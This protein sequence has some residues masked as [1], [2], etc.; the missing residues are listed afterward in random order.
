[1]SNE[2][3]TRL[4]PLLAE[5]LVVESGHY[6]LAS[7]CC[8]DEQVPMTIKSPSFRIQ[9]F[10]NFGLVRSWRDIKQGPSR[11]NRIGLIYRGR[12]SLAFVVLE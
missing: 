12:K 7:S 2:E 6:R 3:K 9:L 1:M 10:E 4:P 5:P 11:S 8:S